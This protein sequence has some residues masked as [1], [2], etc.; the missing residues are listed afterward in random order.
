MPPAPYPREV[1]YIGPPPVN[2]L[3]RTGLWTSLAGLAT[4]G[5]L[6]PLGLLMSMMALRKGPRVAATAGLLL[7][8]IGSL[9]VAFVSSVVITGAVAA[10][11]RH[12]RYAHYQ[13]RTALAQAEDV[14]EGYRAQTGRLPEGI[15]GNKLVLAFTD[16]WNSSLRYDL[17]DAH[18]AIRSAGP[19]REFDTGDDV[20]GKLQPASSESPSP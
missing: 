12:E 3:G 13:T 19:D 11:A 1:I 8:L 20:V 7:G 10:Q 16:G 9:W 15:A 2:R 5:L 18:Y 4:C 6:S 14:V 17:D